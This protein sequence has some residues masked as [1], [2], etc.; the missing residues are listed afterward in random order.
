MLLA[1]LQPGTAF[2]LTEAGVKKAKEVAELIYGRDSKSLLTIDA[3]PYVIVAPQRFRVQDKTKAPVQSEVYRRDGKYNGFIA[4]PRHDFEVEA[5]GLLFGES[6]LPSRSWLY[7]SAD[8]EIFLV[9]DSKVVP[10]F[11]VLPSKKKPTHFN[12]GVFH[13]DGFQGEFSPAP[14]QCHE[15]VIASMRQVLNGMYQHLNKITVPRPDD[16]DYDEDF[17]PPSDLPVRFSDESFVEL[18]PELLATGSDAQ[19]ALGCDP[20]ENVYGHP[21]FTHDNPRQFPY[22]MAGGHIHL[23]HANDAK[24]FHDRAERIIRA[25]DVFCGVPSVALLAGLED[26]RRRQYYGRAGEFR[27]Q[28]HGLEYRTLSNAW[29][30]HQALAHLTLNMARGAFRIGTMDWESVFKYDPEH[31]RNIINYHDVA[32]AKKFIEE[33]Y[34]ILIWMLDGDG[35]YGW[36]SKAVQ[37]IHSGA[38]TVFGEKQLGIHK[39]WVGATSQVTF[40]QYCGNYGVRAYSMPVPEK[41]PVTAPRV[42]A[43]P[44]IR[45]AY[46]TVT[47]S[48][49]GRTAAILEQ[50]AS[51]QSTVPSPAPA[52]PPATAVFNWL[53]SNDSPWRRR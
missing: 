20:S 39:N 43:P 36:G 19:V 53:E 37:T 17:V 52:D 15:R 3:G 23:G 18:T 1:E 22:R 25:M 13:E 49:A 47:V 28:K 51:R 40:N 9:K 12:G 4:D 5:S 24:W 31:I 14:F 7:T 6:Y 46:G 21:W 11:A 8:P 34:K 35:G 48:R 30:Q 42:T 33:N 16:T 45:N 26:P 2:T 10:G 38:K 32:G 41:K 44:P 27:F 50:A 29:L